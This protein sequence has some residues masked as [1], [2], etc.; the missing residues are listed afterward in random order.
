MDFTILAPISLSQGTGK[1]FR[2]PANESQP[3]QERAGRRFAGA[4]AQHHLHFCDDVWRMPVSAQENPAACKAREASTIDCVRGLPV[5]QSR[6][7]IEPPQCPSSSTATRS[8]RFCH[9]S[10]VPLAI[11]RMRA[12][13]QDIRPLEIAIINLMA[14]KISTER[15]LALWLGNTTLQ[16][17][18]SFVATDSYVRGLAAGRET[19]E[20]AGRAHSQILQPLQR[21]QSTK[22]R[23]A[24]RHR[25]QRFE[26]ARRTGGFLAG[27][28]D[29]LQWS[30]T[31][32]FSSLFLCWG[33][34]AAL[35]YFHDIDS[36]ERSRSC[37][38]C[39]SIGSSPTR[40]DSCSAFPICFRFRCRA[41]R[42]RSARIFSRAPALEI[43]ADSEEAGPNMLVE[44]EPSTAEG[45]L[46]PRRVY[47]LNHP[48]Y[49]TET[50]GAEYRRDSATTR[51]IRCRGT[52][53]RGMILRARR[54]TSG[55]TPRYIYTNWVKAVYE[56]TPYN[57]ED[58]PIPGQ[59]K[60]GSQRGGPESIRFFVIGAP[61]S[62]SAPRLTVGRP[63]RRPSA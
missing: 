27:C 16:V 12:E 43:V 56:S 5:R 30:T 28:R 45:A 11:E 15:Q 36:H 24:H 25:R 23:R 18:L 4:A 63:R 31:H 33:A 37:S 60:R 59:V 8:I 38:V 9:R 26:A 6:G 46:F 58:I 52:I 40:P 61:A 14:D 3:E 10:A 53:F 48:E 47:I 50:L 42:A 22:I 21:G 35:K 13:H 29:V 7:R 1:E 44:L 20:Y 51:P 32:A 54:R 41:G 62:M 49:E 2:P 17:N 39:S 34:K 55:G 19:Q 57:I